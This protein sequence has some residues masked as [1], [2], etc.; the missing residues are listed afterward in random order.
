MVGDVSG[1]RTG[2]GH[3]TGGAPE[4]GRGPARVEGLYAYVGSFTSSGGR[5]V[6]TAAV[7]PSS[8]ALTALHHTDAAV[9]NPSY[10]ALGGGSAGAPAQGRPGLLYAVSETES[11]AVAAFSLAVP[12]RP[13]LLGE[14]VP[15]S[16]ADPTHLAVLGG[17]VFTANYGSGS[18]SSL[19]LRADGSLG[20]Q[21]AARQHHGSGPNAERQE[22][23]HAHAVLPDPSGRWLLAADLGTDSVF[24]Y[25]AADP[26]ATDPEAPAGPHHEVRLRAGT[27]P[28]H[29]RFH[30]EGG[31][32]YLVN[33]LS[34]TVTVCEWD[35]SEG[36]L[37]PLS[38]TPTVPDAPS[39]GANYPSE[40]VLSPDAR[41]AW[42][43]NRG[44]DSIAVFA[45]TGSG[46]R[47]EPAGSVP[48]GGDW[49]R[50]LALHPSGQWLYAANERSGDV[51]WFAVDAGTGLPRR[52]GSLA[53]AAASCIVFG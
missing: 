49:P 6:T 29:L 38:E 28:R 51:T 48:C 53:V 52:T 10:L 44:H 27:G 22:G 5:G 17:Q 8:G 39:G 26:R 1:E 34:S 32:A 40:V 37:R 43:A 20:G 30:P 42:I 4:P 3:R 46:E 13:A 11:G 21:A 23:P 45:V 35:A 19:P 16:G 12:D 9:P 50:D 15:V 41:Y 7:D 36:L 31:H 25:P 33:E 18:V 24:V 2:A 14:P 47:L